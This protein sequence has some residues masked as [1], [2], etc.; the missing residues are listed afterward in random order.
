MK[1]SRVT[2]RD[3]YYDTKESTDIQRTMNKNKSSEVPRSNTAGF[4]PRM[5]HTES[6]EE[7]SGD[8]SPHEEDVK[9]IS[10]FISRNKYAIG[11]S[12]IVIIVIIIAI[13]LWYHYKKKSKSSDTSTVSMNYNKETLPDK[14]KQVQISDK[15]NK[16]KAR[17]KP[18]VESDSDIEPRRVV[19]PIK[20]ATRNELQPPSRTEVLELTKEQIS[21]E[22]S[23][24]HVDSEL[25]RVD[26]NNNVN[27]NVNKNN[28]TEQQKPNIN[29]IL[30][31]ESEEEVKPTPR[32]GLSSLMLGG[33]D[34]SDYNEFY[35]P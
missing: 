26:N 21:E 27:K 3:Q 10:T 14:P 16:V 24:T 28:N 31:D 7:P 25:S 19:K 12:I 5:I 17:A 22:S 33:E 15:P 13:F 11:I 4:V 6:F 1:N 2:F 8:I 35:K 34:D 20:K 29:L 32:L 9:G 30:N 23:K 18:I